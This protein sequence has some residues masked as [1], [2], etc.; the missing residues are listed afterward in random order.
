MWFYGMI[1]GLL[2]ALVWLTRVRAAQVEHFIAQYS[3][4]VSEHFVVP[5]GTTLPGGFQIPDVD[6]QKLPEPHLVFAKA[7]DLLNKYD[8]PDIW[9]HAAQ[10]MDKDPGQLARM[11]LGIDNTARN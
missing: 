7:R 4:Q 3:A 11:H 5:P 9:L 2:I 1:I 8:K 6:L 10:M